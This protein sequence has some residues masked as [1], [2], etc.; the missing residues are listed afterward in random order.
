MGG[1]PVS[2][3]TGGPC[4]D[5]LGV[6]GVVDQVNDGVGPAAAGPVGELIE[7]GEDVGECLV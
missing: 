2:G 5:A 1:W 6:E 4:R 7:V 3:R